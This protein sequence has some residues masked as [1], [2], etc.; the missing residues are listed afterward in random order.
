MEKLGKNTPGRSN[1]KNTH[2]VNFTNPNNPYHEVHKNRMVHNKINQN[3]VKSYSIPETNSS[4]LNLD[5]WKLEDDP[6][7][8]GVG[9]WTQGQS[10]C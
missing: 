10:R 8:L 2:L 5:G 3:E 9:L 1:M 6:F 7:L 4:H